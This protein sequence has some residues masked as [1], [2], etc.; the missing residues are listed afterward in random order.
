MMPLRDGLAFVDALTI[1]SG[2][3]RVLVQMPPLEILQLKTFKRHH[4]PKTPHPANE[5]KHHSPD[6]TK[7]QT[8]VTSQPVAMVGSPMTPVL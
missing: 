6:N 3:P 7:L 2:P 4:P 8:C 1:A 5:T